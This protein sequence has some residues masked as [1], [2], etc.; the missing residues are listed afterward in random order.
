ML[1]WNSFTSPRD[2][3]P[4]QEGLRR[5]YISSRL[6]RF[7]SPET[8]IHYK[9]DW[10]VSDT[11]TSCSTYVPQRPSSIT[12]RIETRHFGRKRRGPCRPR[13]HHPLQEGLRPGRSAPIKSRP[14]GPETIIHYK[15]DWDPSAAPR[16]KQA[17]RPQRPSSI[18]RRIETK[19]VQQVGQKTIVPRDH[20]PLQEGLRRWR[21]VNVG[22]L[23]LSP[24]TI[25]HY[26]KD[27]D[28]FFHGDLAT[29]EVPRDHHPLQE[30]LRPLDD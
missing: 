24:E 21:R 13:D 1:F 5:G 6:C 18:T 29:S 23:F 14:D 15:K 20:H 25:I 2:H 8:I 27:W 4:L 9:K 30:G 10:D 19:Q 7:N 11:L 22:W 26:K 17:L 28:A 12:R 3:H 16:K